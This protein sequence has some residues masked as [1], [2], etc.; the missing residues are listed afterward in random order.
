MELC[1]IENIGGAKPD[2]RH[3]LMFIAGMETD[4]H[5]FKQTG[6]A[7]TIVGVSGI[8]VPLLAGLPNRDYDEYDHD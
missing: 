3:L 8:I 5:E 4:L 6:K 2:W 7:S 1:Q